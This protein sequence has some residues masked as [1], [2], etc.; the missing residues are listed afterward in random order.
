MPVKKKANRAVINTTVDKKV[1]KSFRDKCDYIGC[2]MNVVLE[3]FMRQFAMGEFTIQ[4]G[5]TKGFEV[6][7][8]E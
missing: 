5:K 4:L 7:L 1:L 6:K 2:N 8:D 3:A